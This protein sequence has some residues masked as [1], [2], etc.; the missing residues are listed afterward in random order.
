[1][2]VKKKSMEQNESHAFFIQNENT[3][4]KQTFKDMTVEKQKEWS[5]SRY[6]G[7]IWS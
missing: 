7:V 4:E 1:M 3:R 2:N 6:F 5:R